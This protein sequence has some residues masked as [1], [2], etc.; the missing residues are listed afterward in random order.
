MDLKNIVSKL[1]TKPGVYQF[2][3]ADEKIIYI[4]KAKNLRN[5]VSTY[6][7]G[8][9]PDAKTGA[10]VRKIEEI[11]Y[12]VVDSERDAF[13]LENNLIKKYK[14]R[15]NILLKDDKSYPWITITNEPFPQV[16]I[17]RRLLRNGSEY[18]GP[19][20]SA[21]LAHLLIHLIKTIYKL[22]TCKFSLTLSS[23]QVG[24]HKVCLEYHLGNCPAPCAGKISEAEYAESI[25][26]IRHILKGNISVVIES[27]VGQ[28]NGYVRSLQFEK[29]QTLKES[30][31]LMKSYQ[32]KS[33]IVSPS[34]H[35]IDVF[36][37]A[38]EGKY[39]YVNYLRI[40]HGAINQVHSVE[41]ERRLDESKEAL[42]AYAIFDIRQMVSSE[43]KDILVPFSLDLEMKG[44]H[45]SIPQKGEKKKL[46]E[47]S[48]RNVLFF[49]CDRERQRSLLKKEDAKITLLTAIQSELKLP[50]LPQRI[51]C[52]DNS[53]LQGS[54]PVAACVVFLDGKPAKQ[55]YR[56]FHVK[57]V[58][59]PDDFASMEEIVYRRYLRVLDEGIGLPDL[60]VIDGGKGQLHAALNALDRLDLREKVPIV[61]LAKRMEEIY[62]PDD[63]EPY[64]LGKDTLSLKTLMYIRNEAHRFGITFHRR[65]RESKQLGSVLD[66]I[67]GVGA[68]TRIK[69]LQYFESVDGVRAASMQD[70]MDLVG[71]KKGERVF[72]YLRKNP[73]P[74]N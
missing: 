18:Y 62:Y 4:G 69:L 21:K 45:F 66:G 74:S 49:K 42:L 29:A 31:A 34:L 5:R 41:L 28:M 65:M 61:G 60:I 40:M 56:H 63:S 73:P 24:K 58:V 57:T 35:D 39:A 16:Y 15:Y 48:E 1:P 38:E 27:M 50:T 53:N 55:E 2:L 68:H 8:T 32:A 23:M 67:E 44:S 43:S 33:T 30:I 12:I 3:D 59:G 70:I 37:Y 10:L 20:T 7:T 22:R 72:N 17:T 46:L 36:S 25:S 51:E 19:Y 11:R 54:N 9:N 71:E 6:F 64:L 47:L 52:F 14:P 13:L 26:Q